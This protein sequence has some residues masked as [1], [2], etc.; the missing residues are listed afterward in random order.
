MSEQSEDQ[1]SEHVFIDMDELIRFIEDKTNM[2]GSIISNVL[3][4]EMKYLEK[5]GLVEP[6]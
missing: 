6:I 4:K 5:S 3:E 1:P 2:D